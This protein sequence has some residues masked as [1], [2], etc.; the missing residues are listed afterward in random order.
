MIS[1]AVSHGS[2]VSTGGDKTRFISHHG[3]WSAHEAER[4]G[5]RVQAFF[6]TTG[7]SER[8]RVWTSP[9]HDVPVRLPLAPFQSSRWGTADA[10]IKDLSA[11][12]PDLTVQLLVRRGCRNHD[13]LP[14]NPDYYG[15]FLFH[16][17]KRWSTG[18]Q[19]LTNSDSEFCLP[20]SSPDVNPLC[21]N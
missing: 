8:P 6:H 13:P 16:L 20:V 1:L 7:N 9:L 19:V 2:D 21:T 18:L 3:S 12:N 11:V 4:N 10:E 5:E 15:T 14:E 17:M